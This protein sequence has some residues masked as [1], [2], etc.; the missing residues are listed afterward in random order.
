MHNHELCSH[1]HSHSLFSTQ[2][3][4]AEMLKAKGKKGAITDHIRPLGDT[5][6]V[7][8]I[9]AIKAKRLAKIRAT[10]KTDEDLGHG[11]VSE[12]VNVYV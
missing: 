5:M 7:E 12:C 4:F 8:M 3:H 10:I 2:Q 1:V 9:A 11:N 6:S